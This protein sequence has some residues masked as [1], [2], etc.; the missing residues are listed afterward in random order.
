M[1]QQAE[2]LLGSTAIVPEDNTYL[3]NQR[4]GLVFPNEELVDKLYLYYLFMTKS[5]REQLRNSSSGTKVKHTSPEKIYD[6]DVYIPPIKEQRKIGQLLYNIEQKIQNNNQ[7]INTLQKQMTLIYD[8]WFTQFDFP[9]RNGKPYRTSGGKLIWNEELQ[10]EI[11]YGWDC[12]TLSNLLRKNTKAFDYN[13]VQPTIDLSVMPSESIALNQL[14]SSDAFGTNLF[15]MKEGDILFG[16]IRP[17]LKKAGIAP[18]NG[19]VTG[20]IHSYYPIK[21]SDYNF[22]LMTISRDV[23]FDY[24]VRMSTGTKMPVISSDNLLAY[25]IPYSEEVV[26]QF[27]KINIRHIVCKNIQENQNLTELKRWLLPMFMNGQVEVL[28]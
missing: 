12:I 15:E 25:K 14:N 18:C 2:G 23:F 21:D 26:R 17:Y 24:A 27:N 6:V 19:V 13:T 3:H 28:D 22:T 8:Y 7:I 9:D 4:I 1:T 5:V 16:S 10:R 20:T 11:P